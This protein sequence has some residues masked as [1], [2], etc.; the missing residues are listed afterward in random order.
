M[1]LNVTGLLI[2]ITRKI[3]VKKPPKLVLFELLSNIN[4]FGAPL[5]KSNLCI[6]I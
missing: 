5:I 3:I 2:I 4:V 1:V 6:F